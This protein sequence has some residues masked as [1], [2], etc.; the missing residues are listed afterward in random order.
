M[1]GLFTFLESWKLTAELLNKF[2]EAYISWR[3]QK[4]RSRND[5][6]NE[7]RS[8]LVDEINIAIKTRDTAKLKRLNK[9]LYLAEHSVFM[10]DP[11]N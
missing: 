9:L 8:A 4:I 10:S 11:E 2:G 6:I 7:A 1:S 5:A 3:V